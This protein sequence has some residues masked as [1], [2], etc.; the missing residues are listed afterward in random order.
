MRIGLMGAGS[1]PENVLLMLE[2]LGEALAEQGFRPAGAPQAADVL[3]R[4]DYGV[5]EGTREYAED[6]FYASS[7]YRYGWSPYGFGWRDPFYDPFW[8]VYYGRPYF[9]RWGGD[10]R[11]CTTRAGLATS[12]HRSWIRARELRSIQV[13]AR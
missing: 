8:G 11:R 4:V 2:A 6:P 5:D 12:G 9:S 7:R 10:P 3:V 1:R 13:R